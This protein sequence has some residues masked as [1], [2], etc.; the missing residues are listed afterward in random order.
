MDQS[1]SLFPALLGFLSLGAVLILQRPKNHAQKKLWL[2]SA[3]EAYQ[4]RAF[5]EFHRIRCEVGEGVR[6]FVL[7]DEDAGSPMFYRIELPSGR[8]DIIMRE[9]VDLAVQKKILVDADP[10]SKRRAPRIKTRP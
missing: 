2:V 8:R 7:L 5:N 10:E 4:T 6:C 1:V 9:W 3:N